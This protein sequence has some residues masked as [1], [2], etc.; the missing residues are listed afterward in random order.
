MDTLVMGAAAVAW[1]LSRISGGGST[2]TP[3]LPSMQVTSPYGMRIHPV[4]GKQ[5]FHNGID[6]RAPVGT[7][8]VAPE[9]GMLKPMP[10]DQYNG[11][12]CVLMSDSGREWRM[13]HLSS[14]RLAGRVVQGELLGR[15]GST[16]RVTGPHLHLGLKI[17]GQ[18]VDPASVFHVEAAS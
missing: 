9:P 3:P 18:Y 11:K 6:L 1:L 10:Q 5:K 4:T 13:A 2:L 16:G 17:G 15:T 12:W 7:P 14:V 8:L